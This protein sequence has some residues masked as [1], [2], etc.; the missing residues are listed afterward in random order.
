M[1]AT[2][3]WS[4]S[5]PAYTVLDALMSSQVVD[6]SSPCGRFTRAGRIG[7]MCASE[8]VVDAVAG[9]EELFP[10]GTKGVALAG[11]LGAGDLP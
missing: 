9:R 1:H 3:E 6:E 5:S 7:L 2:M 11:K 10:P 4:T 8:P